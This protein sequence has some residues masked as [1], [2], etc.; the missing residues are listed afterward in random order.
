MKNN[1]IKLYWVGPRLS[2]INYITDISFFGSITIFGE[3]DNLTK[4]SYCSENSVRVNHNKESDDVSTFFLETIKK[5]IK[6]D[7]NA[8]FYFYNPNMVFY[9]PGLENFIDYFI[10]INKKDIL[11][12]LKNKLYF[13]KLLESK[14]PTIERDELDPE[15]IESYIASDKKFIIQAPISSGGNGTFIINNKNKENIIKRL[16]NKCKYIISEYKENNIPINIHAV[17]FDEE[18]ILTPGSVQIIKE[19]DDRLLYRGAD[20]LTYRKIDSKIRDEFEKNVLIAC[21]EFQKLGYRGVC[22]IDGM[23]VGNEVYLLEMNNRFQAS[24]DLI[25]YAASVKNLPSIQ[26]M[27]LCA[28]DGKFESVFESIY[29]LEINNSSYFFINNKMKTHSDFI[30]NKLN[31]IKKVENIL[32]IDTDGFNLGL[33][34]EELAYRYKIIFKSNITSI[35]PEGKIIFNEN[36]TEPN[37]ELWFDKIYNNVPNCESIEQMR[38]YYLK[39]KI[40]L[41]VQGA[42]VSNS[43][44]KKF[45]GIRIATNNAIDIRIDNGNNYMIIN[46]PTNI[47]FVE[48]SPFKIDLIGDLT[49]LCY[50]DAP[51]F[52]IQLYETDPLETKHTTRGTIYSDVA[53]LSTDRLRVHITN[54][55]IF[56]KKNCNGEYQG[57]KFCNIAANRDIISLDD[58]REVVSDYW[59][60]SKELS[61]KH[62][63]VGGQTADNADLNLINTIK[64]IREIDKDVPIYA[65]VIPYSNETIE[66]MF[67]A[68]MTQ[69][70]CN[71]EVFDDEIAKTIMPGKRKTTFKEYLHTLKFA[72]TLM[73]KTGN[74]RSMVILGLEKDDSLLHGISEL[75]KNGI[76]PI[77]SIFR[78][79]PETDM[80]D[81]E[82]PPM[83]YLENIFKKIIDICKP[84]NISTGPDCINCQNNTLSL[85]NW[86]L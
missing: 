59:R 84:Y 52:P 57:C 41:L 70:G 44:K 85:P 29:N 11:C 19:E 80:Q 67:N 79:L 2:D 55:C 83:I 22:G 33:E 76:Q 10:N 81:L 25:N 82:P 21:K 28:M 12:K 51:L 9:T 32:N 30:F 50:Y 45:N 77:L 40:S 46:V 60:N 72:T 36:V 47:N 8:R 20:F 26:Y 6:E 1:D 18:I 31:D 48:F 14:G 86:L 23:I 34:E 74:V 63:L 56:K 39:L 16:S 58:T 54:N 75:V 24:T 78:P 7:N 49:Y 17:I 13:Y 61:L 73:G 68:G 65:M 69:L 66:K 35:N 42:T 71:I 64:I 37:K 3:A 5:I 38:E 43:V 27:N 62:F 4:Y 15:E 53:F